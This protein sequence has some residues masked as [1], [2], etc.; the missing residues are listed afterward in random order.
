MTVH[1]LHAE[2][3]RRPEVNFKT[4]LL[5]FTAAAALIGAAII[6]VP[7]T[8]DRAIDKAPFSRQDR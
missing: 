7:T 4:A 5:A 2:G 1:A 8:S 3:A 6:G